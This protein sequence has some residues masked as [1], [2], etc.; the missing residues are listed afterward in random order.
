ML[1]HLFPLLENKISAAPWRRYRVSCISIVIEAVKLRCRGAA[2]NCVF[3]S[4]LVLTGDILVQH[5]IGRLEGLVQPSIVQKRGRLA[6]VSG[7][8]VE[9]L[10]SRLLRRRGLRLAP[11]L[12]RPTFAGDQRWVRARAHVVVIVWRQLLEIS[13]ES[14]VI[15]DGRLGLV[16]RRPFFWRR[17]KLVFPHRV[18]WLVRRRAERRNRRRVQRDIV[19]TGFAPHHRRVDTRRAA[20]GMLVLLVIVGR[21]RRANVRQLRIRRREML[22]RL[23]FA[24]PDRKTRRE[25]L[26]GCVQKVSKLLSAVIKNVCVVD[27][28]NTAGAHSDYCQSGGG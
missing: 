11:E 21:E 6:T 4:L 14:R 2:E 13:A 8:R 27:G 20:V 19:R 26:Q 12:I 18:A 17:P 3:Q 16:R 5:A 7:D 28:K 1:V 15:V 10:L 25:W 24:A 23:Q 22:W 9:L